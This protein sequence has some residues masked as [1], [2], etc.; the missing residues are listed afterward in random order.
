M[1]NT[2]LLYLLVFFFFLGWRVFFRESVCWKAKTKPRKKEER[3]NEEEEM[4][5]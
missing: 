1:A 4:M 2:F 3:G 5:E